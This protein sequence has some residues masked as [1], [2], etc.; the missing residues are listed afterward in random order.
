MVMRNG[1]TTPVLRSLT[2]RSQVDQKNHTEEEK[3]LRNGKT[4][5]KETRKKTI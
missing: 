4:N 3:R 1:P 5:R 2:F